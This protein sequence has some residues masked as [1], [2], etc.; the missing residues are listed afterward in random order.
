M[1]TYGDII[2]CHVAVPCRNVVP[3]HVAVP[4]YCGAH[5]GS[6]SSSFLKYEWLRL[7]KVT[8]RLDEVEVTRGMPRGML[9]MPCHVSTPPVHKAHPP[10]APSISPFISFKTRPIK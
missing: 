8:P 2:K 9:C 3:C 7:H 1:V 4:W 5:L 6:R 10:L